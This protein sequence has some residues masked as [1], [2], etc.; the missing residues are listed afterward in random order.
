MEKRKHPPKIFSSL[1][2]WIIH[3]QDRESLPGDFEEMYNR[4][5]DE[6]GKIRAFFWY[7]FHIIKLIPAFI[8]NTIYWSFAM[9]K[10]Y[11]KIAIRS[12]FR[13]RIY[14]LINM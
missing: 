2:E 12:I 13:Q 7:L 5:S 6:S 11:L 9:F 10:N 3:P 1:L 4:I 14:S 8:T